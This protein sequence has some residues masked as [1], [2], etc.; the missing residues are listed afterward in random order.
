M[1]IIT[2]RLNNHLKVDI[3]INAPLAIARSQLINFMCKLRPDFQIICVV[4]KY[5][6]KR[7][8]LIGN[9]KLTSYGLC[10]LVVYF[11]QT[12]NLLPSIDLLI[13]HKS[14]SVILEATECGFCKS[15]KIVRDLNLCD[16]T[17]VQPPKFLL[18]EFFKFYSDFNFAQR[19]IMPKTANENLIN[20]IDFNFNNNF[21]NIQD[22]FVTTQNTT[23]S[24]N[25]SGFKELITFIKKV[26]N[27]STDCFGRSF[28]FRK[29]LN[30]RLVYFIY[31][32]IF[33]D[34]IIL[35]FSRLE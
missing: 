34:I 16:L 23:Y 13:Q 17:S 20:N 5:I 33:C 1:P 26:N 4:L 11:F 25:E 21:M 3:C 29:L 15:V 32:I 35:F 14:S 8:E 9:H 6:F 22:I 24:I 7:R 19:I 10:M 12:K 28:I 27:N 2:I 31:F 18:C 30:E